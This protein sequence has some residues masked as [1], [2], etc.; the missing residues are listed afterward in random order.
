MG[1]RFVNFTLWFFSPRHNLLSPTVSFDVSQRGVWHVSSP[2]CRYQS[3]TYDTD[4]TLII[5]ESILSRGYHRVYYSRDMWEHLKYF[6]LLHP[7]TGTV[8][9]RE[10]SEDRKYILKRTSL[11][12]AKNWNSVWDAVAGNSHLRE[13]LERCVVRDL[14]LESAPHLIS[15]SLVGN[16]EC[17]ATLPDTPAA[18]AMTKTLVSCCWYFM[19]TEKYF[20]SESVD[21]VL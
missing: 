17:Q 11:F 15:W 12:P 8:V 20:Y 5:E 21:T 7:H 18:L 4:I 6:K 1:L 10:R 14:Y 3:P 13:R 2:I 9:R 16:K 19:K